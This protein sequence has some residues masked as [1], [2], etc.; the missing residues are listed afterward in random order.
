MSLSS[1]FALVDCNNFYV[2]CERVFN[3][4]LE[5]KPVVVLS[6][7]D[8]CI[9]A[10][11]NEAK[12]LGIKMG[13]A[14]FKFCNVIEHHGVFVFS[15]N[16]TLYGDMSRR[17]FAT[18]ARF[19]PE[20][21][22]YS[23]DEAFLNLTGFEKG[24]VTAYGQKIRATVKQWTGIPVSIGIA[25]TKTL[26]KIAGHVA[27]YSAK[28][29]GVLDLTIPEYRKEALAVTPVGN[30]WGIGRRL[31]KR[32]TAKGIETALQLSEVDDGWIRKQMGIMGV[33]MVHELCGVSCFP[34]QLSA[35][36]KKGITCSRSFGRPVTTLNEMKEAVAA[37]ASRAAVELRKQN[38]VAGH[39]TVYMM[40][41][42]F[43][44]KEPRHN[45]EVSIK[46]PVA[47]DNTG[48]LIHYASGAVEKIFKR[49]YKYKKAGVILTELSPACQS[50]TD[51]FD[52]LDRD[53]MEKLMDALDAVN[54][55]MGTRTLQFAAQGSTQPWSMRCERRSPNYTTNWNELM[56][57]K[58]S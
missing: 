52:S 46:L 33:R 51:M 48:E 31:S 50:Q 1:L 23:I 56:Q 9:V 16:Y 19:A 49:G 30:V 17:V 32:L 4:Q 2:S 44:V 21:E 41:N 18:L 13:E 39:L 38:S 58:A 43:K 29:E 28:V 12:A 54:V 34:L 3:P 20:I 37:Y 47:T 11:S 53:R 45:E 57:A 26:A 40:T 36:P 15:S 7:N 10:R 27:K 8:G 25:Q 14:F 35:P 42:R 5:G 6:N 22:I 55:Q 24:N